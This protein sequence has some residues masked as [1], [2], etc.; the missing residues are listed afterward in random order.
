MKKLVASFFTAA[1]LFLLGCSPSP[2][3]LKDDL[4]E[5]FN[6]AV[7]ESIQQ[8]HSETMSELQSYRSTLERIEQAV[9][10]LQ[11]KAKEPQANTVLAKPVQAANVRVDAPT[12]SNGSV[13]RMPGSNWNVEGDWNYTLVELADHLRQVHGLNVDGKTMTELQAMHDNLHNGYSAYGSQ[14]RSVNAAPVTQYYATNR[15]PTVFRRNR[16]YSTCPQGQP[17]PQ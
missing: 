9:N 13:T 3:P 17:C 1:L 4:V 10:D 14:I 7:T 6:A 15:A 12:F 16:T 2:Q 11:A 8:S 5:R